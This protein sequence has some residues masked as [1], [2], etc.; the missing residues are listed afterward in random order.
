MNILELFHLWGNEFAVIING[1]RFPIF[2]ET[3]GYTEKFKPQLR[4]FV[5]I[6][7]DYN[8]TGKTKI[9]GKSLSGLIKNLSAVEYQIS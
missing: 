6:A 9:Y 2:S 3:I 4:Y 1:K 7:P 8:P 5:I